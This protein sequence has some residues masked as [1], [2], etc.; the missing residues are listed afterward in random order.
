[1]PTWTKADKFSK[2]DEIILT[3][4]EPML[5]TVLVKDTVERVRKETKS[6]IYLYT[7]LLADV[8]RALEILRITDGITVTLHEPQDINRFGALHFAMATREPEMFSTKSL[9]LNVFKEVGDVSLLDLRPWKVKRNI[10]WIKNCPL[11]ESEVFMRLSWMSVEEATEMGY[12]VIKASAFEV[13]LVKGEV[14][15][16]T[17]FCQDF[18]RHLPGLDHPKIQEAI[19]IH[20]EYNGTK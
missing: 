18:D 20:E 12:S 13:G 19:R 7:S 5:D 3:G 15:L 2:F 14:G 17:W 6:P 9:R 16:N 8:E 10:E 11:P 4:G 1:L